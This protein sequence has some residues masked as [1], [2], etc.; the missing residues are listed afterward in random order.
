MTT[1]DIGTIQVRSEEAAPLP[2]VGVDA[3][4]DLL[5]AAISGGRAMYVDHKTKEARS[6]YEDIIN[7]I[8]EENQAPQDQMGP[9]ET[10]QGVPLVDPVAEQLMQD[11]RKADAAIAQG[12]SN[13]Q[14]RA[15]LELRNKLQQLRTANPSLARHFEAELSSVESYDPEFYALGMID[16]ANKE[17]MAQTQEERD[18]IWE[19]AYERSVENGGWGLQPGIHPFGSEAFA[20]A[21]S[22][23]AYTQSQNA[24]NDIVLR[25]MDQGDKF[26]ARAAANAAMNT[27]QGNYNDIRKAMRA[28]DATL[29]QLG[30]AYLNPGSQASKELVEQWSVPGGQLDNLQNQIS[31]LQLSMQEK[32][33]AWPANAKDSPEYMQFK[34]AVGQQVAMLQSLSDGLRNQDASAIHLWQTWQASI[35]WQFEHDNPGVTRRVRFLSE[36]APIIDLMTD[37]DLTGEG[38]AVMHYAA[39]AMSHW[40]PDILGNRLGYA[41]SFP[42]GATIEEIRQHERSTLQQNPDPY[43][44]GVPSTENNQ[45]G[46]Y[47]ALK[48]SAPMDRIIIERA[49]SG[50]AAPTNVETMFLDRAK[51]L[52]LGIGYKDLPD[53]ELTEMYHD[54]VLPGMGAAS[55]VQMETNPAV[56]DHFVDKFEILHMKYK[57]VRDARFRDMSQAV[58]DDTTGVEVGRALRF[59]TSKIEE[60][61]IR[62]YVDENYLAASVGTQLANLP[63]Q[64]PSPDGSRLYT[65]VETAD[66]LPAAAQRA[67]RA[68]SRFQ[69]QLNA[70]LQAYGTFLA[71]KA[72]DKDPDYIRAWNEGGFSK[73]FGEVEDGETQ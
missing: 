22:A 54:A 61:K 18:L 2:A 55:E 37:M 70:D 21:A 4:G 50:T 42:E 20:N 29:M 41:S 60:G 27:I 3:A 59:D 14:G 48:D 12:P 25:S 8:K 28:Y 11:I 73:Y 66:L 44:H 64:R 71:V 10:R 19:L 46:A 68:A 6:E 24:A 23:A 1:K 45:V 7:S 72:G 34:E 69:A 63:R 5:G 67:Q 15:R 13:L 36:A 49:Q 53:K 40:M 32:L 17:M 9:P 26:D 38:I 65:P 33:A 62:V 30:A 52:E 39:N 57:P 56:V 43:R 58:V 35:E 16:A 31:G 47:T 51:N